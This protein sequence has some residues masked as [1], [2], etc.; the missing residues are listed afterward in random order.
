MLESDSYRFK[1]PYELTLIK[2]KILQNVT[3]V[4]IALFFLYHPV[5]KVVLNQKMKLFCLT[6][7]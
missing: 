2:F 4:T 1:A 6:L 5:F 7:K 3:L